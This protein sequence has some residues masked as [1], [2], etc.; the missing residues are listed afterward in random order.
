MLRGSRPLFCA[1][2]ATATL[3]CV[4]LLGISCAK[5]QKH[6]PVALAPRIGSSETGIASWYGIPYH[7]R[8]AADGEIYDM[9]QLVAAHRTLPFNTWVEVL[10]LDNNRSVTVRIIDRGPFID[11]RIIDLSKAAARE[12][13]M[14]GPGIAN[15]RMRIIEPPATIQTATLKSVPPPPATVQPAIAAFAV[16]IGAFQDKQ[17]A[18]DLRS[19]FSEEYGTAQIV[20]RAGSPPVWRVLVGNVSDLDSA[21]ALQQRIHL[22]GHPSFV[23]RLD[24][25]LAGA[26]K[27][28]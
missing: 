17:R 16:Q 13:A 12:I 6:R 3:V 11:G 28:E 8:R 7:G 21:N 1:R 14:L 23:V 25:P 4:C 26:P 10:N 2:A 24:P 27:I 20:Y 5:K 22:A 15:V 19:R 9:E 18:E